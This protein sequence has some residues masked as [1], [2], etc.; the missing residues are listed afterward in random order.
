MRILVLTNMYP[1]RDRPTFG[2][3]VKE[4]VEDLRKIG[5]EIDLRVVR[6]DVSSANYFRAMA[7]IRRLVRENSYDAIHAHY[8]IT[9]AVALAQRVLPVVVT[10]HGSD[11]N[12]DAPWQTA[13]S[14]VVSRRTS[15]IFVSEPLAKGL[16]LPSAPVIPAAV[17]V[18]RFTPIPREAARERLGWSSSEP[19]V[20]LPGSRAE[21][22]KR[23]DLF[24][25]ALDVARLEQP[26]I[27]GVSLENLSREEVALT[28]NA[29]DAVLMTSNFEGSPVA[30]K[31]AL[32]CCTPVVS[33]P[34][35]DVPQ[36][37]GDLPGCGVAPRAADELAVELLKALSANR[38]ML[39]R[40]RVMP[41]SRERMALQVMRV[42]E[43]LGARGAGVDG[44]TAVSRRR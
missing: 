36:L 44:D 16:G 9:G 32:A 33:V 19:Y 30:V 27:R 2:I 11:C 35:A 29:V 28:M 20:L 42:Y 10:F 23:A 4:Q 3:F 1:R 22:R 34:V 31:E 43:S 24:D 18:D 13:V 40:E 21:Y 25:A 14:W 41:F 26:S 8:G 12:G 7:L 39:L 37:I 38:S 17:D 15:P 5:C 6:G